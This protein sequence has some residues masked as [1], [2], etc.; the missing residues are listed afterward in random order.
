MSGS[1]GF[2]IRKGDND[3]LSGEQYR[4]LFEAAP[5]LLKALKFCEAELYQYLG[6]NESGTGMEKARLKGIR[7][8]QSA[9]AKAEGR[10]A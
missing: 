8:A 1:G 6:A 2:Y 9:I 4:R 7:L 10:S 3:I 5:D